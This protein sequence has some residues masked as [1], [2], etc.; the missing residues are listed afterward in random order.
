MEK[1]LLD[2][3]IFEYYWNYYLSIEKMLKDT[4]KYVAIS[5]ENKDTYSIEF[6]KIILLAC[7]EID[8]ILKIICKLK[9]NIKKDTRYKMEVYASVLEEFKDLKEE[10]YTIFPNTFIDERVLAVAPFKSMDKNKLYG[11]LPWWE[12]YQ[13][14]K[15]NRLEN[16][17]N[18][19][20]FNALSSIAA[21]YIL[22]G[23]L[24]DFLNETDGREYVKTHNVSE[25][26]QPSFIITDE[27]WRKFVK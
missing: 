10:A 1:R 3:N 7:A 26:L 9:Q 18:G 27:E 15:H 11:G 8:S 16:A 19:N 22:I 2:R 21:Y 6:T 12:A 14:L 17:I 5:Y 24:K 13:K 4:E 20:L 25:Y 23:I